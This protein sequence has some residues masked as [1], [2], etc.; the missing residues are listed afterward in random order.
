MADIGHAPSTADESLLRS[1]ASAAGQETQLSLHPRTRELVERFA[2]ALMEKLAKA[3]WKYG[4]SDGWAS[5]GWLDVCRADLILHVAKGDPLDV[6]AYCAFLWHHGI[7]TQAPG[8][9]PPYELQALRACTEDAC[10]TA[11]GDPRTQGE[12]IDFGDLHCTSAAH[13]CSDDGVVNYRVVIEEADPSCVGLRSIISEHLDAAGF[14]G[15]EVVIQ[16]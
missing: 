4:Y 2:R 8:A 10:R 3:E 11:L 16:W 9:A 6:A 12:A 1:D 14:S 7:S 5:D 13:M 15:V